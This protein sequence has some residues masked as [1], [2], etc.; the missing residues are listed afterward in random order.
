LIPIF[1]FF[2]KIRNN[3]LNFLLINEKEMNVEGVKSRGF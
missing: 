2:G 1:F 3:F